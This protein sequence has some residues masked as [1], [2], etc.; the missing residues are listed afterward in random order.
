M[1][2]E[3]RYVETAMVQKVAGLPCRF[4]PPGSIKMLWH[5]FTQSVRGVS[6]LGI[7]TVQ[8]M[9]VCNI[10]LGPVLA[11]GF[12]SVFSSPFL[13]S[14]PHKVPDVLETVQNN[15]ERHIEIPTELWTC[16]LW[17]LL[18]L[19]APISASDGNLTC[20]RVQPNV[21][22]TRRPEKSPIC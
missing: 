13:F 17:C 11:L 8:Y 7:A 12:L 6:W 22:I 19:Q 10:W 21:K 4:L 1:H 16:N 2:F 20:C 3:C 9:L 14:L 18:G 5:E 15:L